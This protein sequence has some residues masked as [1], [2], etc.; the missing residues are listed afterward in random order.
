[1]KKLSRR[2]LLG[3]S[4]RV[5][6]SLA[7]PFMISGGTGEARPAQRRLKVIVVGAHVDDPQSG[8]GGTMA[9]YADLAFAVNQISHWGLICFAIGLWIALVVY[10]YQTVQIVRKYKGGRPGS[11]SVQISQVL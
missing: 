7:I 5:T 4:S 1:M 6:G 8:C 9:R 2:S 3:R 11:A 10:A